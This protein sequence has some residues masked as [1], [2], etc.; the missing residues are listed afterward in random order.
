[1]LEANE[2]IYTYIHIWDRDAGS[3]MWGNEAYLI[4]I[5]NIPLLYIYTHVQNLR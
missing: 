4:T 1:M 2:N 3:E 5:G